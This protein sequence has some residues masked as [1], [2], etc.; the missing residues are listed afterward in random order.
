MRN[1]LAIAHKELRVVLR[2]ADRLHRHR[3]LRAALRRLLLPVPA[4]RSCSQS[5]QMAQFGRQR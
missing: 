5:M 1:I 4:V 2:L 3:L